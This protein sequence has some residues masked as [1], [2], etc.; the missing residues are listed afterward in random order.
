MYRKQS[1]RSKLTVTCM[2]KTKGNIL[3]FLAPLS[4]TRKVKIIKVSFSLSDSMYF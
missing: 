3:L 2:P 4:D 1:P